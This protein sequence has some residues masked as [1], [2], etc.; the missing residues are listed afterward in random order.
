MSTDKKLRLIIIEDEPD[1]RELYTLK[2]TQK[3]YD[4]KSADNGQTGLDMIIAEK[5][6]IV[7]LDMVLPQ[8][9][10]FSVL[11]S[12]KQNPEMKNVKVV[13][14]TNL[15]QEADIRKIF[16]LGADDCMIKAS[17]VPEEVYQ[18]VKIVMGQ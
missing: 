7:L 12:V 3:G 2:F 17:F 15:G 10:G 13:A 14:L 16:D 6:D 11:R 1:L 4:V 9:D 8:L 18:R 5:P